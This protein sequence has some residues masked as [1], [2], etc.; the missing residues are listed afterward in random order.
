[1]VE[2]SVKQAQKAGHQVVM[3]NFGSSYSA[4]IGYD[5][6]FEPEI[7]TRYADKYKLYEKIDDSLKERHPVCITML[8][9]I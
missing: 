4:K 2:F 8:K 7:E 1:M 5:C 9:N 3:A 6:G